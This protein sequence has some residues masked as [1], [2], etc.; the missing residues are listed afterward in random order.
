MYVYICIHTYIPTYIHK[1]EIKPHDMY[2]KTHV[3]A[4]IMHACMYACMYICMYVM[5]VCKYVNVTFTLK[6]CFP[7]T[8]TATCISLCLFCTTRKQTEKI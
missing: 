8:S 1:F 2:V 3:Y 6:M 4:Y 5:C 7:V